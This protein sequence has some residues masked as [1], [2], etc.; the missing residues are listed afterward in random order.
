M[1]EQRVRDE[2]LWAM[3]CHLAAFAG[4]ILPYVGFVVGPLIV[5]AIKKDEFP[6]VSDQGK[7][8]INFQI[9]ML[10]YGAVAASLIVIGIGF[11]LVPA[12]AVAEIVL[13]IVAA[14]A[15]NNGEQYRYPLTIRFVR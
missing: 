12:W 10:I 7:E 3:V 11:L 9:S 5:W 1:A 15:A 4:L 13:V 2:R 14:L 6:L 8:S